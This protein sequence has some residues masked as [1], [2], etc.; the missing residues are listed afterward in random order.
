MS[1]SPI[2]DAARMLERAARLLRQFVEYEDS[3]KMSEAQANI[4]AAIARLP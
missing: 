4:N 1:D 3:K 2:L